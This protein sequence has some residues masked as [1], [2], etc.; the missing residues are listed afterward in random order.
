MRHVIYMA[1]CAVISCIAAIYILFSYQEK[2]VL[3]R[4]YYSCNTEF[5]IHNA[6]LSIP[7]VVT[8]QFDKHT[9]VLFYDNPLYKGKE[10][11]GMVNNKIE[12]LIQS[13]KDF[14]R[15]LSVNVTK[16]AK[17]SAPVDEVDRILP[18]FFFKKG[19]AIDFEVINSK[20]GLLFIHD[21]VPMFFC[22]R[23]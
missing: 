3:E 2:S 21:S 13:N 1:A 12:F 5:T 15:L 18:D 23:H 16:M 19:A 8:F 22:Q 9:G 11:L 6:G 20:V 7:M 14:V 17:D 10:R 4:A